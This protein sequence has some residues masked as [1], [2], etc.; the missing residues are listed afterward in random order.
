MKKKQEEEEK[1]KKEL[2]LQ[3]KNEESKPKKNLDD[4]FNLLDNLPKEEP[5]PAQAFSTRSMMACAP[6][7]LLDAIK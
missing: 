2:E 4:L 3:K 1:K 7:D 6:S 5:K